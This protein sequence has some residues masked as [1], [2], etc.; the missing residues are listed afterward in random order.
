MFSTPGSPKPRRA[1][2]LRS[3]PA[4]AQARQV[5]V[6]HH[7]QVAG[8]ID[9]RIADDVHARTQAVA[10]QTREPR[11]QRAVAQRRVDEIL[12]VAVDADQHVLRDQLGLAAG[13]VRRARQ[14]CVGILAERVHRDEGRAPHLRP[15]LHQDRHIIGAR[16]VAAR[17][18]AAQAARVQVQR[19]ARAA[20][21]AG[22][23]G[24]GAQVDAGRRT[25]RQRAQ[26]RRQRDLRAVGAVDDLAM[27]VATQARAMRVQRAQQ[28]QVAPG[29][30]ADDA[31]LE[32]AGVDA[33]GH[34]QAAAV[35]RDADLARAHFV[36]QDQIALLDLETARAMNLARVQA[37]VQSGEVGQR[38]CPQRDLGGVI[39]HARAACVVQAGR[40]AQNGTAQVDPTGAGAQRRRGQ[41]A[42]ALLARRQVD[43]RADLLV[44]IARRAIQRQ[45]AAPGVARLVVEHDFAASQVQARLRAQAQVALG[46]DLQLARGQRD[47]AVQVHRTARQRQLRAQRAGLP[48]SAAAPCGR[49]SVRLPPAV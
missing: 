43:D 42:A 47:R 16:A 41:R 15:A 7:R 44:D 36:A 34:G 21:V 45:V 46:L 31:G 6:A 26:A 32:A 5:Q 35:H 33:A 37:R 22:G 49:R 30:Q 10:V 38:P 17:A 4:V 28:I 48:G 2:S 14:F 13:H 27:A 12:A 25:Q 19:A 1:G 18:C 29:R 40:A 39:R 8:G 3:E 20:V 11:A 23:L 9:Q 24:A